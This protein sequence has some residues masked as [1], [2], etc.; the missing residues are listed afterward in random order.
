MTERPA[1]MTRAQPGFATTT[2]TEVSKVLR[3]TYTLLGM[4]IMFSAVTATISVVM[5]VPYLGLWML[6]PYFVCLWMV[7]KTKNTPN[8]L[9]AM[10]LNHIS[11]MDLLCGHCCIPNYNKLLDFVAILCSILMELKR[12]N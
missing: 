7:Q 11:R 3:N 5:S 6:A 10:L 2:S 1:V 4:T 12:L 9:L 8:S